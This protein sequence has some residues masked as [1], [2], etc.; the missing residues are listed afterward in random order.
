[1]SVGFSSPRT[2]FV[3]RD[4]QI[5]CRSK[6]DANTPKPPETP[7]ERKQHRPLVLLSALSHFSRPGSLY[8]IPPYTISRDSRQKVV[9][10]ANPAS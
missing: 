10:C 6:D 2:P 3:D 1:M 4:L 8:R 9:T 5:N 7:A